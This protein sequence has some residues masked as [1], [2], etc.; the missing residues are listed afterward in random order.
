MTPRTGVYTASSLAETSHPRPRETRSFSISVHFGIRRATS[1]RAGRSCSSSALR[2]FSATSSG[3]PSSSELS[4]L[5][6]SVLLSSCPLLDVSGGPSRPKSPPPL[7]RRNAEVLSDRQPELGRHRALLRAGTLDD[8]LVVVQVDER[9]DGD[10]F[11]V[12]HH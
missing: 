4:R 5:R 11:L 2:F 1:R 3:L 7:R 12:S 9:G 10:S 6:P 8:S